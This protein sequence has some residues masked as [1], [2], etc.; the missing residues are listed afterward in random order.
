MKNKIEFEEIKQYIGYG[1][2]VIYDSEIMYLTNVLDNGKIYVG[3]TI[4]ND[5]YLT[6]IESIT[7]LV[8]PLESLSNDIWLEILS[9]AEN[10][11]F[12]KDYL[13]IDKYDN[14]ITLSHNDEQTIAFDIVTYDINTGMFYGEFSINQL[15]AINKLAK[16]HGD[17]F[18]WLN[19]GNNKLG[20]NKNIYL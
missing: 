19:R 8:V 15:K 14:C 10:C 7:P 18:N 9:S 2:Q 13:Y 12:D 16:Q 17:V 4:G 6:D 1:L 20:R 5:E 3:S 11:D